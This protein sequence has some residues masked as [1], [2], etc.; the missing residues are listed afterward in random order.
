MQVKKSNFQNF[1]HVCIV[2]PKF[3][4]FSGIGGDDW[5]ID[6]VNLCLTP[7]WGGFK[8]PILV[9]KSIVLKWFEQ[10]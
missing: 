3:W 4:K 5:L 1:V 7:R 2:R 9:I 8:K 6:G 10:R